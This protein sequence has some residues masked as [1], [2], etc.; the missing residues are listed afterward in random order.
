MVPSREGCHH[1]VVWEKSRK[2]GTASPT[3]NA[4]WTKSH[5]PRKIWDVGN[6]IIF[7]QESKSVKRI[8]ADI[9]NGTQSTYY[10]F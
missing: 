10:P 6:H 8:I 7:D 9:L 3:Y 2:K 5:I 1:K 4:I